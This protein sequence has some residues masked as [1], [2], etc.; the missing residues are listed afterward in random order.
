MPSISQIEYLRTTRAQVSLWEFC[1]YERDIRTYEVEV[2]LGR[3][4]PGSIDPEVRRVFWRIEGPYL[5]TLSRADEA[6]E[7]FLHVCRLLPV[8]GDPSDPLR[9]GAREIADN[10][11]ILADLALKFS[12]RAR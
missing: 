9:P 4:G 12:P 11:A 10:A 7:N 5:E 2:I 6:R 3:F 1:S 8:A